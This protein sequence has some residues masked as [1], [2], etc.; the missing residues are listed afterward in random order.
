MG[1]TSLWGTHDTRELDETV[2]KLARSLGVGY[3]VYWAKE[4]NWE[5]ARYDGRFNIY[6]VSNTVEFD[7]SKSFLAMRCTNSEITPLLLAFAV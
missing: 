5:S 3:A 2:G 1:R 4:F 7:D 6:R